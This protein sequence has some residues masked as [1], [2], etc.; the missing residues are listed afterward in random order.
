MKAQNM[1]GTICMPLNRDAVPSGKLGRDTPDESR[2]EF[3]ANSVLSTKDDN[4]S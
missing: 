3:D 4:T 2:V 1:E